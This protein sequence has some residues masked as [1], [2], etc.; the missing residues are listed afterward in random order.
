MNTLCAGRRQMNVKTGTM[1]RTSIRWAL[2]EYLKV[3][4][5]HG[6]DCNTSI[7]VST[8][9]IKLSHIT[10]EVGCRTRDR[11][12][13]KLQTVWYQR[14]I[15][16]WC[17]IDDVLTAERVYTLIYIKITKSACQKKWAVNH[18]KPYKRG[19]TQYQS[20]NLRMCSPENLKHIAKT[21]TTRW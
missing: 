10:R 3:D 19:L 21:N 17:E 9:T 12:Q 2:K 8:S 15:T 5:Y 18:K 7:I 14:K 13:L 11:R 4:L 1:R 16:I 20:I 6:T